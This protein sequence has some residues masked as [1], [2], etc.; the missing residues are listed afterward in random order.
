MKGLSWL[1]KTMYFF[2]YQVALRLIRLL[3]ELLCRL[4]IVQLVWNWFGCI[5]DVQSGVFPM[6]DHGH[7]HHIA[8]TTLEHRPLRH[9]NCRLEHFVYILYILQH[10][11][12]GYFGKR[13]ARLILSFDWHSW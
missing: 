1:H 6:R 7:H 4:E 11:Q 9:C 12:K 13:I 10:L 8:Y 5:F 3:L 2:L